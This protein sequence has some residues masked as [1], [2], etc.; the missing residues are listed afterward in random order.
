MKKLVLN[1]EEVSH[2]N[3]GFVC[4]LGYL[5]LLDLQNIAFRD[6]VFSQSEKLDKLT[7]L[8]LFD[9][10]LV[11]VNIVPFIARMISLREVAIVGCFNVR[12]PEHVTEL[13]G[14]RRLNKRLFRDYPSSN[15]T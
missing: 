5:A 1:S 10:P 9:C 6:T 15:L 12:L 7:S 13:D 3:L 2:T 11:T 4:S 14:L 8:T